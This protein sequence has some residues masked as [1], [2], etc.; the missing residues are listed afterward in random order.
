MGISCRITNSGYCVIT[1]GYIL[2]MIQRILF[3]ESLARYNTIA[4]VDLMEFFPMMLLIIA[5]I[6]VGI[7][8][9]I[10]T[11]VFK[12]EFLSLLNGLF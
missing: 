9:A 5:I 3:G 8:P 1:A 7:Y 4:D 11:D 2:W 12:V 6:V 10:L